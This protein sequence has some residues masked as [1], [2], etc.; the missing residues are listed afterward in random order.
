MCKNTHSKSYVDTK[1]T[2]YFPLETKY[3][4]H[5][6]GQDVHIPYQVSIFVTL[7]STSEALKLLS[8]V[9]YLSSMTN[10]SPSF[11]TQIPFVSMTLVLIIKRCGTPDW[12]Q[13][14]DQLLGNLHIS[15]KKTNRKCSH[16]FSVVCQ[17]VEA[18]H[19]L[20]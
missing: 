3:K 5:W 11:S 13:C 14:P 17:L 7:D 15:V 19:C 10:L 20:T 18:M 1:L 8:L 16:R 9:S 12:N 6:A 4:K 2:P